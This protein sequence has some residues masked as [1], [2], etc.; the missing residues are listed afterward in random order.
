MLYY[1]LIF[2]Y[3][4]CVQ[5]EHCMSINH[6]QFRFEFLKLAQET[7]IKWEIK[8]GINC[9]TYASLECTEHKLSNLQTCCGKW[10]CTKQILIWLAERKL[11]QALEQMPGKLIL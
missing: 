9:E 3:C 6:L 7:V 11:G 1:N 10:H 2:I 5:E 8:V 4:K